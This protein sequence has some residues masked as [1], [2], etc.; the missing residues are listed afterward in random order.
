MT[1]FAGSGIRDHRAGA[2][3]LFDRC[4]TCS[5]RGGVF[6]PRKPFSVL[7]DAEL[8]RLGDG[9]AELRIPVRAELKQQHGFVHGGVISYAADNA[10]TLLRRLPVAD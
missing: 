3:L 9:Q 10:L 8:L 7:V 2:L 4:S 6:S 5:I 1:P